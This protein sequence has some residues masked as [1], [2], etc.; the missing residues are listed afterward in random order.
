MSNKKRSNSE[1]KRE[2]VYG[3]AWAARE[4]QKM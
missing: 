4:R 3:A 2:E 1:G